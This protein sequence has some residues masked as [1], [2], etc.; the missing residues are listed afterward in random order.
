[1]ISDGRSSLSDTAHHLEELLEVNLS[2]TVLINLSNG[3]V[4]LLLR[5]DITELFAGEQLEKLAAVDLTAIVC[6]KHLEGCLK[7]GLTE[8]GCRV[9]RRRQEL[10][11]VDV[12]RIVSIGSA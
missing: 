4:E 11:V 10:G 6:V 8:E 12:A 2:V 1:M 3:L 9:H 7:V 5:V